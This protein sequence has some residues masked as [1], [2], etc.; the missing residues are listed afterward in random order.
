MSRYILIDLEETITIHNYKNRLENVMLRW[1]ENN[2]VKNYEEIYN[3]KNFKDRKD[4]LKLLNISI[5]KY[6]EWYENFNLIE[7]KTYL[8]KYKE[9]KILINDD[10]LKFIKECKL[11]LILVSNSSPIWINYILGEYKVK[12][13]FKYIFYRTYKIDDAKKPNPEVIKIIE[14]DINDKIDN[15]SIVIGDSIDDYNFAKNCNLIFISMFNKF[16]DNIMFNN[17]NDLLKYINK[18]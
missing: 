12:N 1:L 5:D 9:N 6:K 10:T 8:E 11:P 15:N 4:R 13:Y 3:N 17:F 7:H 2:K 18:I 16:E 14:N